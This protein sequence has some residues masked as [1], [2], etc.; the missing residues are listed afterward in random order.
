MAG[1]G[2][3]STRALVLSLLT[4]WMVG[5][6]GVV[7]S[8][9]QLHFLSFWLITSNDLFSVFQW[10]ALLPPL[11][12]QA[13]YSCVLKDDD[14]LWKSGALSHMPCSR[15]MPFFLLPPW[16]SP[17][18]CE[19][20]KLYLMATCQSHPFELWWPSSRWRGTWFIVHFAGFE[21]FVDL[22]WMSVTCKFPW[23]ALLSNT[24]ESCGR[25]RCCR[26]WD[27][28]GHAEKGKLEEKKIWHFLCSWSSVGRFTKK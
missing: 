9:F 5:S 10:G 28:G 22:P 15:E 26:I 2:S 7:G 4:G 27:S 24:V 18:C 8:L 13:K 14:P 16:K 12:A 23:A 19:V 25:G 6:R 21:F 17:H 11:A 3:R 20:W 1:E